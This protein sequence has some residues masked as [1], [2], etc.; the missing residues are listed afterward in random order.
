MVKNNTLFFI[1][2]F[3]SI[4]LFTFFLFLF[5]YMMFSSN[6]ID[7]YAFKKDEYISISLE[8]PE[9]VQKTTKKSV[10]AP[11]TKEISVSET[12]EV[13][14]ED[15]FSDVWTKDIKKSKITKPKQDN[16]RIQEIQKR[17]KTTK[18]NEV[19]T[20]SEKI[21]NLDSIKSD[22]ENKQESTSSEVNEY[23]AKIHALVYQNFSVPQN[24]QGHTVKA[25][26]KLSPIGKV[27]DFRILNYSANV[28][29]NT[30]ADKIKA[31]LA[32]VVFPR[33]PQNKSG[34]YIILLTSKE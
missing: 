3:I 26:I 21:N 9:I 34:N 28:A 8:V 16:K 33:N 6:T 25:V 24:S 1:S 22:E 29:L 30:E 17:I 10:E 2:G 31:R 7:M 13:D 23:L 27:M 19:N 11:L 15:L 18:K 4:L 32:S 12:K 5:M 14:I 20:L